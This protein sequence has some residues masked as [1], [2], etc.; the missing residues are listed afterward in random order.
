MNT[1]ITSEI[2][3][4][5]EVTISLDNDILKASGEKGTVEK[6]LPHQK[7]KITV[8]E[9]K[10]KIFVKNATKREKKTIGTFKAHINNMIKGVTEGHSYKLKICYS[11]FPMNVSYNNSE[12]TIKNFLGETHPRV[13]KIKNGADV[14][15]EGTEITVESSDVE[16]A[17]QAAADI[18]KATRITKKDR[19]I[20]QDGI[21]I[22]EKRG[23]K[24]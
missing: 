2:E 11:H 7:V 1:D 12:L 22:V 14:K 21:F 15:I 16:L 17:G 5:E 8:E 20:F 4:P 6:K 10:I 24:I 13:V 23:K 19:R 3:I 9:D 18:E